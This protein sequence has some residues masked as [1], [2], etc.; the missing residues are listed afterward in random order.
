LLDRGGDKRALL[1]AASLALAVGKGSACA[2]DRDLRR[3]WP[4]PGAGRCL[5]LPQPVRAATLWEGHGGAPQDGHRSLDGPHYSS[6]VDPAQPFFF[7]ASLRKS[8]MTSRIPETASRATRSRV[9]V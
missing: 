1:G 3:S 5:P 6:A 8:S 2:R 7:V 9:W 4:S